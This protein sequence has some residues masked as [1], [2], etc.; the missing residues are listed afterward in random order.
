M[1][2]IH[3]I[4][5]QEM[6]RLHDVHEREMTKLRYEL[7]QVRTEGKSAHG[8]WHKHFVCACHMSIHCEPLITGIWYMDILLLPPPPNLPRPVRLT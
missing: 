4:Q 6:Q 3:W 5:E 8:F 2:C 7:E 1:L